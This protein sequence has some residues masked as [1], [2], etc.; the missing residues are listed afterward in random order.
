MIMK[1]YHEVAGRQGSYRTFRFDADGRT[2]NWVL[3]DSYCDNT[4][5]TGME[6]RFVLLVDGEPDRRFSFELDLAK[7]TI[8]FGPEIEKPQRAVAV[9]FAEN[10]GVQRLLWRHRTL[11]RAW[12]VSR[13]RHNGDGHFIQDGDCHSFAEFDPKGE[14][15]A[16]AFESD[17]VTW[18]AID[19]YC[20]NP[21]CECN[22][23][24][25]EFFRDEPASGGLHPQFTA[26][27]DLADG[28]LTDAVS[29]VSLAPDERRVVADFQDEVSPWRS[30]LGLRRKLLRRIGARRMKK[31]PSP[32]PA[33]RPV[34]MVADAAAITPAPVASRIQ[35][36]DPCLCGSGR[37]YKK[38][39]GART[40][41]APARL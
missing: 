37:K 10:P 15:H 40:A 8:S 3:Q 38:C 34:P 41:S 20:L 2:A 21:S 28:G 13:R 23:A 24:I 22:E 18:A 9:E 5:C 11:V 6:A 36:N 26:R 30:E 14:Q 35:R 25:L 29:S 1:M 16:M 39:C 27:L 4:L 12:A 33:A 7:G 17:G 32:P 31:S 19:A